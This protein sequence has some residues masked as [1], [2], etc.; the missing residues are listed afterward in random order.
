MGSNLQ[1]TVIEGC[2]F[3]ELTFPRK[4]LNIVAAKSMQILMQVSCELTFRADAFP[5]CDVICI[6]PPPEDLYRNVL[7]QIVTGV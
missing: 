7:E 6:W 4:V 2:D 5:R 1:A 3:H